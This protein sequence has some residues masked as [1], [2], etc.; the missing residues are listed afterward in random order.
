L[1]QSRP[2]D[3]IIVVDDGSTD[4]TAK[5]VRSYGSKVTY[6][7]QENK[8][9]AAARNIGIKKSAGEYIAFLDS[10][11][12]WHKDKLQVQMAYMAKEPDYLISH[13]DEV[14]YRRGRLLNQKKK[15]RKH[16]GHIFDKCLPLCAVS[17]STVIARRELFAKAG[18]FDET[19]PCCEDYDLW[20]RISSRHPFLLVDEPLTL[21]D[22]GRP[23]QVSYIHRVGMDRYR[24]ASLKNILNQPGLL[25][26]EQQS[27]ARKEF[28]RKCHIYGKGCIKHGKID[29]GEHYLNL[30]GDVSEFNYEVQR[31][32]E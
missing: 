29:E 32:S 4:E 16:H 15:H 13:T 22:G 20:L 24:I 10:D 12:W 6:L 2:A 1:G 26:G 17:P 9:P 11:D 7:W 23:D 28:D 21:K 8:G 30:I 18:F 27:L 31:S 14:W 25:N 3:E 19:L 5:L